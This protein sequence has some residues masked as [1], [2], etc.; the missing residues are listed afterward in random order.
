MVDEN[1]I[2][3]KLD[4]GSSAS[5]ILRGLNDD[6]VD[7]WAA[8]CASVFAYKANPPPASYFRRHFYNDPHKSARLI[9]VMFYIDSEAEKSNPS[10]IVSSCRIFQR[11]ISTGSGDDS[12]L[13]AGG[14]GEVCTDGNHRRRGLSKLLLQDAIRIMTEEKF[15]ISLLHA[16]PAF[17]PVYESSGYACTKSRWSVIQVDQTKLNAAAISYME[18]PPRLAQLPLDTKQL[19]SLHKDFTE[20]RFAGA[21]VRSESY[22]NEYLS[23]ELN[24]TLWVLPRSNGEIIAWISVRNRGEDRFQI[25]EFGCDSQVPDGGLAFTSIFS[26]LL[27]QAMKES[28]YNVKGIP[29]LHLPTFILEELRQA[30]ADAAFLDWSTEVS[31]DDNGWMYRPIGDNEEIDMPKITETRPHLIWPADSF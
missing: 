28:D 27:C 24:R 4:D 6:E 13:Q 8:F 11:K 23:K 14:I 18:G 15:Q 30:K 22:W 25:R 1:R 10:Q 7:R 19:M 12:A 26:A 3:V 20:K 16:A 5:Y 31:E 2:Q 29:S 9:R 21:I 17:F